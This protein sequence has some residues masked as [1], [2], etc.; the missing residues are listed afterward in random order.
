[1]NVN[2]G[3]TVFECP[4]FARCVSAYALSSCFFS[5]SLSVASAALYRSAVANFAFTIHAKSAGRNRRRLHLPLAEELLAGL[6]ELKQVRRKLRAAMQAWQ[7]KSHNVRKHWNMKQM[8]IPTLSDSEE[9]RPV[10]SK[11]SSKTTKKV[12]A[13]KLAKEYVMDKVNKAAKEMIDSHAE[14]DGA[15]DDD[16]QDYG[17]MN[18]DEY[19]YN[20]GFLRNDQSEPTEYASDEEQKYSKQ[21]KKFCNNIIKEAGNET[22]Y[23]YPQSY[24]HAKDKNEW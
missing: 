24:R 4:D 16:M 18:L 14:D 10:Q 13:G 6:S 17:D 3:L 2:F 8:G 20:D 21:I 15:D 23:P 19:D 22:T 12:R 5:L 7:P 9:K 1:M 11:K